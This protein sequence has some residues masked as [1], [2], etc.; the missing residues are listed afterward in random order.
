[1]TF[2]TVNSNQGL[3]KALNFSGA[4]LGKGSTAPTDV[5]I[6]TS[7]E[8][9]A[10][11]FDATNETASIYTSFFPDMDLSEDMR[12][13]VQFALVNTQVNGDAVDLTFDYIVPVAGIT[14]SGI[15]KA[16]TQ[17]TASKTIT[18]GEG[19]AVDDLYEVIATLPA[20]DATN[21]ITGGSAL[22]LEMHLTNVSGVAA[23]HVLDADLEYTALY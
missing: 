23:M 14:G 12:I 2:G 10:L 9:P 19:L 13:R 15:T 17:V 3:T 21:P 11:L 22:S 1:M 4:Q 7:P 16:S 18:T 20:A 8:V 6:G 5:L